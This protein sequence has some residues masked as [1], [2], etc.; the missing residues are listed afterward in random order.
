[1]END[2]INNETKAPEE[3]KSE[4]S[5]QTEPNKNLNKLFLLAVIIIIAA[6][7]YIVNSFSAKI[8]ARFIPFRFNYIVAIRLDYLRII[9]FVSFPS[10]FLSKSC[11]D[12]LFSRDCTR[13]NR[14]NDFSQKEPP[15]CFRASFPAIRRVFPCAISPC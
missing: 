3:T 5:G 1:M 4:Q 13:Y 7:G 14:S 9:E 10:Q 2:E 12:Y 11:P 8:R 15:P 6:G